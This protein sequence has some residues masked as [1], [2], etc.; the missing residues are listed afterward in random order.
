[1]NLT[2]SGTTANA[3]MPKMG[4]TDSMFLEQ[5]HL[6]IAQTAGGR[7]LSAVASSA[8]STQQA[9]FSTTLKGSKHCHTTCRLQLTAETTTRQQQRHEIGS[10][11]QILAVERR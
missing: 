9:R 3:L 11:N 10:N 7:E 2:H 4:R 6:W 8:Q 1:L 5:K